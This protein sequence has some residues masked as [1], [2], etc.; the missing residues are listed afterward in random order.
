MK[1]QTFIIL[2][3]FCIAIAIV[4]G[5]KLFPAGKW[6]DLE[7]ELASEVNSTS[8]LGRMTNNAHI[9]DV[10]QRRDIGTLK[11]MAL[12]RSKPHVMFAGF[13]GVKQ[14]NSDEAFS[15]A[16]KMAWNEPDLAGFEPMMFSVYSHLSEQVAYPTFEAALSDAMRHP[17]KDWNNAIPALG[18]INR[19]EAEKWLAAGEKQGCLPLNVA[20][21]IDICCEDSE[22]AGKLPEGVNG[23]LLEFSKSPGIPRCVYL[24]R[25]PVVDQHFVSVL[26]EVIADVSTPDIY[27]RSIISKHP[28]LVTELLNSGEI[29]RSD[30]LS[31][32]L[33][34]L[35]E[36][37]AKAG[38]K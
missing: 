12:Q 17:P 29:G 10:I 3:G 13:L 38:I 4:V 14:I 26:K 2:F 9:K 11:Q 22:W 37:P 23:M 19:K 1:K 20:H 34:G 24:V 5:L 28:K 21:L 35:P 7:Q 27:L 25:Y 31:E 8:E 30:R 32:I 18:Q 16:L 33:A 6:S 15:L 36:A